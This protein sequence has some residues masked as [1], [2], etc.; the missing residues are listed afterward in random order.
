MSKAVSAVLEATSHPSCSLIFLTDGATSHTT[1]LKAVSSERSSP[2]GVTVMEVTAADGQDA[3][4]TLAMLSHL[5]SQARRVRLSS[6]CVRVVVVSHDPAFLVAFAE[7]SLKGRLLVWATRL[8]VVTSLTLPQLYNLMPA[9]WTFAMMNTIFLNLKDTTPN[10][11]I[12]VYT[13]LP[14]SPEG[15]QLVR[16]AS[17]TRQD[18][19]FLST[20]LPLSPRKFSNF[21]GATVNVTALPFPPYWSKL[22]APGNTT[23]YSGTDYY[24]LEAIADALNFTIY[25]VPTVTWAEVAQRV[26][27]KVSFMATV[28]H[29]VLPER[30]DRYDFSFIYEYGSLDF[31]MAL[32]G[33]RPQWQSLYYPLSELVW[34]TILLVLLLTPLFLLL[35]IRVRERREGSSRIGAGAVVQ[36]MTGMLLG[37]SLPPRLPTTSSSRLLVAAWLVFAF[38]IGTVYRGNLTAHLTLPKYPP[39]PETL[40]ELVATADRITMPPYGAEFKTFFSK[41]DSEVFQNLASLMH[42]VES[43]DVGQQQAVDRN[44]GHLDTRRYQELLIAERFTRADG[45]TMLYVGRE[46]ILPGQSAWPLPHDAPY[47]SVVDR[48]IMAV[49]EA[50][51]YEKWSDDLL[52]LAQQESSKR[53]Q[54]QQQVPKQGTESSSRIMALT[55]TH[56]QGPLMLLLLGLGIAG[57]MF[58]GEIVKVC[59]LQQRS[60]RI[61]AS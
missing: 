6:W 17:W 8:L 25:V 34:A 15:A 36:D 4:V 56:M 47:K 46:S 39:R 10:P 26:E 44:Q 11:R 61:R 49:C 40:Q 43:V 37:Q 51:L 9:H 14:Y 41:S 18:G 28:F 60:L 1:I 21:Y 35:V 32:P 54:Q 22:E 31:S 19:L 42:I 23:Q 24:L 3:N 20:G 5:V 52:Y 30:L 29:N 27:E 50:G 58:F 2:R 45:S 13:H 55:L 16:V 12:S 53:Q 33:V 7:S 59:L 48:C 57:L 38:I